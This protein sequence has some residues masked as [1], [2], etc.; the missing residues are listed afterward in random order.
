M[1]GRIDLTPSTPEM[2]NEKLK[3]LGEPHDKVVKVVML[4]NRYDYYLALNKS[5]DPTVISR[6]QTALD[7]LKKEGSYAKIRQKHLNK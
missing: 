5:V 2:M 4:D 6:L 3:D 1:A 7:E